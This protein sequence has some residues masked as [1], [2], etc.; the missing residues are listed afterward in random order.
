MASARAWK[1]K[2]ADATGAIALVIGQTRGDPLA[3]SGI[4][5]PFHLDELV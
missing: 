4:A 1:L 3:G 2:A 5:T